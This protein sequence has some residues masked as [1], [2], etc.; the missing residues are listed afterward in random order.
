MGL[1]VDLDCF[2]GAYSSFDRFRKAL[3]DATVPTGAQRGDWDTTPY[4]RD[5]CA[6]AG[7]HKGA[8]MNDNRTFC[9]R[10]KAE[11]ALDY[12][13]NHS[14]CDGNL[15]AWQL[16]PLAKRLEEVAPLLSDVPNGHLFEGPRGAALRFAKGLRRAHDAGSIVKFY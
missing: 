8:G 9:W 7:P 3:W 5:Y 15:K 12:L 16:L 4:Y 1:D 6:E 14:D 11:D 2:S 10:H 13:L